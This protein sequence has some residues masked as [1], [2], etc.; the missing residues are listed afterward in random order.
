[1]EKQS[2]FQWKAM[3]PLLALAAMFA[4][5]CAIPLIKLGFAQ[6][7][8][9]NEDTAAKTLFAGVRFLLAG[10]FT[11]ALARLMH[12]PF[13]AG[14]AQN[15]GWVALLALMD[16]A[17]H[18]FFFYMGVSFSSG[19]RST[20]LDATGTF[21]LVVMGCLFFRDEHMTLKKAAGCVLGFLGLMVLN[22][23]GDAGVSTWKGDALILINTVCAAFGG[24]IARVITRR[25]D[26]VVATGCS[27]SGG[28]VLLVIVGLLMGG[29]LTVMTWQG[30]VIL[31]LLVAISVVGFTIYNQ[32]LRWHPVSEVAIYRAMIPVFGALMSCLV[33][34]EQVHLQ[35][36]AAALLIGAGVITVNR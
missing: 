13:R 10:G 25:M 9:A 36:A 3:V 11:L 15:W 14:S 8:V 24:I 30:V 26:A 7:Q 29:R 23:G 17:L 2:I 34:G 20:M 18:Y 6:F 31:L 33:L 35:L 12:R 16:T 1:M 19:T 32:L 28:G 5:G 21:L 4:W 22:L 27:L